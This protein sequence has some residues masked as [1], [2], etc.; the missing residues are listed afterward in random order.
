MN[1]KAIIGVSILTVILIVLSSQTNVVGYQTVQS[2]VKEK[3]NEKDLLF[4]TICDLANNKEIQ[5]TILES[6]GKFQNPFPTTQLPSTPTIVKKQLN[7]M[8]YLGM[9]LSR[10]NG[11]SRM[12]SMTKGHPILSDQ[13]KEKLDSI[14]SSTKDLS[15]EM[16]QLSILN[17][18]SCSESRF[19]WHFPIICIILN[20][21]AFYV[22]IGYAIHGGGY[23]L[24]MVL[25]F[26]AKILHCT[27][28]Y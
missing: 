25:L 12:V 1:T 4:Q 9:V 18:P 15:E 8:Y 10:M 17:C 26:T 13:T 6:Q 21:I 24:I 27:W 22:G 3:L 16:A 20:M 19:I 11:K 14:I 23:F 28:Y 2:S 5:K 7:L